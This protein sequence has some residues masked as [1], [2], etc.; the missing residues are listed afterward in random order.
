[1]II[2]GKSD[3]ETLTILSNTSGAWVIF[4]FFFVSLVPQFLDLQHTKPEFEG[5]GLGFWSKQ[6]FES[7]HHDFKTM[8]EQCGYIRDID[9]PQYDKQLNKCVYTYNGR[10]I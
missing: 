7:F 1:M 9:N 3:T 8:W 10:H 5:F 6:L 4:I 2:H